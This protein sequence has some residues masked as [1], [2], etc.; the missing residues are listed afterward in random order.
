MPEPFLAILIHSP[1]EVAR[2]SLRNASH[3]SREANGA[4]GGA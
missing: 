3:A 4:I 1:S 2:G